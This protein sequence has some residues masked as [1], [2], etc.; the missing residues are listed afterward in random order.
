MAEEILSAY[1]LRV[2]RSSTTAPSTPSFPEF[3][4]GGVGNSGMG[5]YHGRFGFEAFTNVRGVLYH[6]PR[7]DP[8]VRYPSYTAHGGSA[9]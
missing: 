6:S 5:K 1:D 3:P 8:G 9:S 2:T 4:F 7:I